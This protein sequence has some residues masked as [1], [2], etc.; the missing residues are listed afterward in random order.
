MGCWGEGIDRL[1]V[2]ETVRRK[3]RKFASRVDQSSSDSDLTLIRFNSPPATSFGA[4]EYNVTGGSN[5]ALRD[6]RNSGCSE[7]LA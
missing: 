2:L 7:C 6:D 3:C 5:E 4:H 1:P